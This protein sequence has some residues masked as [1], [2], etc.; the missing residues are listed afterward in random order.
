[1]FVAGSDTSASALRITMFYILSCPRV[2]Q[3]LKAE[4][5]DAI[6]EGRV[7]S[8]V[9][10]VAEAKQLPYLQVCL[11]TLTNSI[12]LFISYSYTDENNR[13]SSTKASAC[14]P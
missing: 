4:I 2:Y 3:K 12:F 8:P 5:R 11:K 6:R 1:M 9:I 13:P 14:A 7:S 10:S